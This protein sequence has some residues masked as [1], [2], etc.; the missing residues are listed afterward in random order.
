MPV[1]PQNEKR[2]GGPGWFARLCG[3][4]GY[5][6]FSFLFAAFVVELGAFAIWTARHGLRPSHE[7][8][9][10]STSPSYSD[11]PWSA[12][13]WK[14]EAARRKSAR[15]K[16][17]P[18]RLWGVTEWHSK[19]IN[20]DPSDLGIVRRTENPLPPGCASKGTKSIWFFGGSTTYGSGVPD[21]S[22]V[23]SYLSRDLNASGAGCYVVTNLGVEG[24][25]TNQELILLTEEIKKGRH[26]DV[27]VFLDGLNDAYVGAFAPGFYGAHWA[28]AAVKA[29][30]EG[31][32]SG[33]LE[34]L[35]NSYALRLLRESV[36]PD[37]RRSSFERQADAAV[38]NYLANLAIARA[39]GQKYSFEVVAFWQPFIGYG[40]KPLAPYESELVKFDANTPEGSA[41]PAM[42]AVYQ[43]AERR[44][45]QDFFSLA[46]AFDGNSQ[47]L[48][49]DRWSHLAPQGNEIV[50]R[51]I[52]ADLEALSSTAPQR[53]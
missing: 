52:A 15:S 5:V 51:A 28:Y 50:A 36:A 4:L 40:S 26:P 46:H 6:V 12:E 31:S 3:L 44:K 8:K 47:S 7:E 39:L 42:A 32:L 19:Y 41:Y 33:K 24:Y 14:E 23:P 30:M 38:D 22:T 10:G 18:F 11:F 21:D 34:F 17:V 13:F 16:Y 37:S 53:P 43:E 35:R 49:I 27:A 1:V 48:Y 25:N 29:R 2:A 9:L 45:S 20:D